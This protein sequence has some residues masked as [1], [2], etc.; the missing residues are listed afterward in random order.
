[1]PVATDTLAS[2]DS[3]KDARLRGLRNIVVEGQR[4]LP[5]G[6][7]MPLAATS[8]EP[9]RSLDQWVSLV[10]GW[11]KSDVDAVL[12]KHGALLLRDIPV[13][14]A[15]DFSRLLH[16]FGWTA[17]IDVGNPVNRVVHAPNVANANEGP[18]SLYIAAHSEFGISSI[19][20]S[21]ICFWCM[22]APD[23][24]G[25]TPVNSGAWLLQRL[26][27]EA[28]EFV[29]ELVAK[30]VRYT[31]YHPPTKRSLD[32]NGNGVVAAWGSQVVQGD[33]DETIK[34]KVEAE[35]QRISPETSWEWQPDGGLFT[36]QRVP[37]VRFHPVLQVPVI[38]SNLA[39]Y[40][41]GAIG[42]GTLEAPYLD[43]E[44]FYKPPPLYGDDSPIPLK[45]LDLVE[46]LT[47]E[48]RTMIKWEQYDVLIIE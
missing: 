1:M 19:F 36:F 31:I 47:C 2:A 45:Y 7:T 9:T 6:A 5:T 39:S 46:R 43:A 3:A 38:F 44:G 41:G 30:G 37:G 40:Y 29:E 35:I 4:T 13:K 25:Q 12:A 27:E 22:V 34:A 28:P 23:E 21:R 42:R 48:G 18:A 20:P 8:D 32:A 16:A 10:K 26:Q 14:S 17:H 24:G 15:N 33:D 11:K